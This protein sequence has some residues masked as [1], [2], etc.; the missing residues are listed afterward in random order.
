MIGRLSVAA[1]KHRALEGFTKMAFRGPVL[2]SDRICRG[3]SADGEDVRIYD[4]DERVIGSEPIVIVS[5]DDFLVR[6]L[7][8]VPYIASGTYACAS[9]FFESWI[10]KGILLGISASSLVTINHF[11]KN[12]FSKLITKMVYN[13]KTC[14]VDI[15]RD[16]VFRKTPPITIRVD[17]IK[18]IWITKSHPF[19]TS[20]PPPDEALNSDTESY[21]YMFTTPSIPNDF[22][23][24]QPKPPTALLIRMI[25][26]DK[27]LL[28]S[29]LS[30]SE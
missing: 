22:F 10:M 11:M 12:L 3:F 23:L 9:L 19:I 5:S 24:V 20:R 21:Y 26:H 2:N 7:P 28:E 15:Y 29:V 25:L 13:P 16:I 17:Q 27:E 6:F 14:T 4:Q 1:F 30:I 8:Y 18:R